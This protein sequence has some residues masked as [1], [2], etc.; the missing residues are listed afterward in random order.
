[1]QINLLVGPSLVAKALAPGGTAALWAVTQNY[2]GVV[3]AI[4]AAALLTA[5]G[6]WTATLFSKHSGHGR[7][8][9]TVA[10]QAF[11]QVPDEAGA[12]VTRSRWRLALH[13]K[14]GIR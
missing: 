8:A 12:Q 14:G 1:M 3:I 4:F 10:D 2:D 6:F 5:V 9:P 13:R 11:A 7:D